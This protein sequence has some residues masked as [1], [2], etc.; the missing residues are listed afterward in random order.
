LSAIILFA[1]FSGL[2]AGFSSPAPVNRPPPVQFIVLNLGGN[3][4]AQDFADI[5]HAFTNSGEQTIAVGVGAIFSY[6]RA[7]SASVEQALREFLRLSELHNLPIVVQ[8]DGEQWW[9][10]RPDL[11]NWW[12]ETKPGFNPSNRFNVEWSGW[13]PAD[14][15][16]IAWRNW[17]R[18]IRVL[19][20][21]NLMSPAYRAACQTEMNRLVPVILAWWR[22]LPA[23]KR[24]LLIGIK[25]GWESSIGVNAWYYPDGNRLADQPVSNDPTN[26]VKGSLVPARGVAQIGYAA[27]KTAGLRA[28]GDITEADLAEVVRR[29]L[30]ELSRD[31][32]KLGV[33]REKLFTHVGGWKEN[34]LLYAAA[35]N[36]FSCPGWSFYRHAAD[37]R[38]DVGVQTA[39]SHSDAPAWAAVEWLYRGPNEIEPWGRALENVFGDPRCRFLCLYNWENIQKNQTA[40]AAVRQVMIR[41]RTTPK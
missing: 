27:V 4:M 10:A 28:E 20:P 15:V 12:D 21:P 11:W 14:A 38:Q 35:V 3:A 34:E 7:S 39:L 26:G 6:L 25:V 16:R 30:A 32:A 36:P 9:E 13:Q 40:Q 23:A 19:P 41:S 24:G 22:G 5:S 33:P 29:H 31:A 8:L 18:I 2:P 17:G 1:A 37:P